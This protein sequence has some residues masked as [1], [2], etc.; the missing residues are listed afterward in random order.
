MPTCPVENRTKCNHIKQVTYTNTPVYQET[1][2]KY[3]IFDKKFS[4]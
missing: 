2:Y 4:P 1:V 3:K